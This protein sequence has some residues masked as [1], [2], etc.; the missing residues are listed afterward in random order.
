MEA[1][2]FGFIGVIFGSIS[3]AA[4]T[5][6]KERVTSRREID[7]RDRQYE[8]DRKTAHDVFQRDSILALQAWMSSISAA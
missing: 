6:Y 7:L 8:R 1:A 2:I 5:I 3:T 4:L